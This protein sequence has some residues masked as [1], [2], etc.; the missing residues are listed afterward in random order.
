MIL[1]TSMQLKKLKNQALDQT[2][3]TQTQTTTSVSVRYN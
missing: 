1:K 2:E 3:E